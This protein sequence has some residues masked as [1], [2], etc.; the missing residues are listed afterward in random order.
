MHS[1]Y[2]NFLDVKRSVKPN[3]LFNCSPV[4]AAVRL[5]NLSDFGRS[6]DLNN[7][8]PSS[9]A[10][11]RWCPGLWSVCRLKSTETF[12]WVRVLSG[13]CVCVCVRVY[14]RWSSANT[15]WLENNSL[16]L[17]FDC[18]NRGWGTDNS[19]KLFGTLFK[20]Q[21]ILCWNSNR[22]CHKISNAHF[23]TYK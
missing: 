11:R 8:L 16:R 1:C 15:F 2:S 3:C 10:R 13:V 19:P 22:I 6:N 21:P 9:P 14:H 7:R 5:S 4:R 20:F 18:A 12:S 17:S 23:R